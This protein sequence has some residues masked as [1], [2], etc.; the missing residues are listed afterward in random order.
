MWYRTQKWVVL[1]FISIMLLK[2]AEIFH[3]IRIIM[4]SGWREYR[5]LREEICDVLLPF[6]YLL[7]FVHSFHGALGNSISYLN[8]IPGSSGLR[9]VF[10][11][12][13]F[14]TDI[15]FTQGPLHLYEEQSR[16]FMQEFSYSMEYSTSTISLIL[17][18][19]FR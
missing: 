3:D 13:S 7:V 9:I 6:L 17:S 10:P 12:Y 4:N 11:E 1:P 18:S 8:F 16:R 19:F 5:R 15:L 2:L 14:S